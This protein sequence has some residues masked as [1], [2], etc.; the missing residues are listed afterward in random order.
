[1]GKAISLSLTGTNEEASHTISR[2]LQSNPE[3][4]HVYI[5]LSKILEEKGENQLAQQY[6]RK[7]FKR[8]PDYYSWVFNNK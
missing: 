5:Y 6:F 3:Y 7:Y 4:D 1:L 2:L 8:H